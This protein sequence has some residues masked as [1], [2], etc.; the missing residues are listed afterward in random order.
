M[1]RTP[2]CRRGPFSVDL[3]TG[4]GQ[5][6]CPSR[7]KDSPEPQR[8]GVH[9]RAKPAE[10]SARVVVLWV[11]LTRT[12]S[13]MSYVKAVTHSPHFRRE[14]RLYLWKTPPRLGI[15][16]PGLCRGRFPGPHAFQQRHVL[17]CRS[18]PG[19]GVGD[20]LLGHRRCFLTRPFPE[21]TQAVFAE[22]PTQPPWTAVPRPRGRKQG[23]CA[24]LASLGPR[25]TAPSHSLGAPRRRGTSQT[26]PGLR[27]VPLLR[28]VMRRRGFARE[29]GLPALWPCGA[30][31]AGLGAPRHAP[32]SPGKVPG[33]HLPTF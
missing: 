17:A 3:L 23:P 30:V 26:R 33:K 9:M 15:R 14:L 5:C 19:A 6:G 20:H 27:R 22:A 1:R 8:I 29:A 25:V 7:R 21:S 12:S 2:P 13:S 16:V 28:P 32:C 11:A 4:F 31:G 18:L 24:G 10:H